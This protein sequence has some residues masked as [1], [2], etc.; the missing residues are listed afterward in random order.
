VRIS[1]P[2]SKA[3]AIQPGTPVAAPGTMTVQ[4]LRL[5]GVAPGS[6]LLLLNYFGTSLPLRVLNDFQVDPAGRVLMLHSGLNVGN[7]LRGAR[8]V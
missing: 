7:A 6:N 4:N 3:V 1:N 8:G 5:G 2:G